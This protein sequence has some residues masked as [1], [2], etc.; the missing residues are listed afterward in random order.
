MCPYFRLLLG[1][2]GRACSVLHT[3]A[4][5]KKTR[6][7][8]HSVRLH[9]WPFAVTRLTRE[10]HPCGWGRSERGGSSR[11]PRYRAIVVALAINTAGR[12]GPRPYG[13]P[14]SPARGMYPPAHPSPA[15]RHVPQPLSPPQ[16]RRP[17]AGHA[18]CWWGSWGAQTTAQVRDDMV[19]GS[20]PPQSSRLARRGDGR[21]RGLVQGQ[22]GR[23][24]VDRKKWGVR[25]TSE[26]QFNLVPIP[27]PPCRVRTVAAGGGVGPVCGLRYCLSSFFSSCRYPPLEWWQEGG[28]LPRTAAVGQS[29][30]TTQRGSPPDRK[31]R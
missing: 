29:P 19:R 30:S 17:T 22:T 2:R 3:E 24:A 6:P 23:R 10:P 20:L 8:V 16:S 9:S 11:S 28:S 18:S 12:H 1:M 15:S 26:P 31:E 4:H 14:R 25:A 5:T 13:D 7:P 21:R 27:I